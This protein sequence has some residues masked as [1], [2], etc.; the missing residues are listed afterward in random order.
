LKNQTVSKQNE[1]KHT[2]EPVAD[3]SS[4]RF[5]ID[6]CNTPPVLDLSNPSTTSLL[7]IHQE[8][9]NP[10]TNPSADIDFFLSHVSGPVQPHF[11]PTEYLLI[12][13]LPEPPHYEDS[14]EDLLDLYED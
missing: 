1:W 3:L 14:L 13:E 4:S 10:S 2:A 9:L 11:K 8:V 12:E 5:P 7:P 6:P